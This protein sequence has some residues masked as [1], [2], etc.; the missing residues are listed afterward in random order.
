[1]TGS[2][3]EPMYISLRDSSC[4]HSNERTFRTT[5]STSTL[6][7]QSFRLNAWFFVALILWFKPIWEGMLFPS[8]PNE[9]V[10]WAT[11]DFGKYLRFCYLRALVDIKLMDLT[12]DQSKLLFKSE[13]RRFTNA[14]RDDS[15][16]SLVSSWDK[17]EPRYTGAPNTEVD[18]NWNELIGGKYKSILCTQ[19]KI[20]WFGS[21]PLLSLGGARGVTSEP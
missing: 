7:V 9:G 19:A 6:F 8:V 2:Q 17:N 1:M 5:P 18:K 4:I 14:I 15:D 10:I 21:R 20:T 12:L 13:K 3:S 11:P 16:G